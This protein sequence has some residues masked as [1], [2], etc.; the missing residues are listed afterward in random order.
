MSSQIFKVVVRERNDETLTAFSV[1]AESHA[2]ARSFVRESMPQ[3]YLVSL[4]KIGWQLDT[5]FAFAT[6]SHTVHIAR[7]NAA[8]RKRGCVGLPTMSV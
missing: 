5:H 2:Q 6:V 3:V 7:H 1:E 8:R 4:K